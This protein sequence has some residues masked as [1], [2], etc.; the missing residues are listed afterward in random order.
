MGALSALSEPTVTASAEHRLTAEQSL[1]RLTR[2]RVRLRFA[3]R[4]EG[5]MSDA[6]SDRTE[7]LLTPAEVAAMFRVSVATIGRWAREGKLPVVRTPGGMRHY[8]ADEIGVIL[9]IQRLGGSRFRAG[10]L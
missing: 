9:T 4:R 8:S 6:T 2:K 5:R 10:A 7:R 1:A 3:R